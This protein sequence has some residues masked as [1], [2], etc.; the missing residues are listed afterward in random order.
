MR[1]PSFSIA[2]SKVG[3]GGA[4]PVAT[5]IGGSKRRPAAAGWLLS[6]SSTVGAPLKC[7]TPCASISSRT[8]GGSMRRR[9]TWQPPAAVT[10]Q[11]MH[12]PLQWNIGSVQRKTVSFERRS[13]PS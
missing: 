4:P 10:A 8:S 3:D 11:G 9:P 5:W 2:S 12:Q 6:M 1:T 13:A 7:V